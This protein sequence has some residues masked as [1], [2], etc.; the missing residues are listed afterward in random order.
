MTHSARVLMKKRL[1]FTLLAL[2]LAGCTPAAPP[3][4]SPTPD[5]WAVTEDLDGTSWL[6]ME[7]NGQ[8]P[9]PGS[10][11]S[12]EFAEGRVGGYAGCNWYGGPYPAPGDASTPEVT[13]T[14][15]ARAC[16]EPPGV[17]EQESA[18]V[19]ALE[20]AAARQV[21]GSRLTF[22]DAAGIGILE[23]E[24]EQLSQNNP[25][26]LVGTQWQLQSVDG[27]PLLPEA[28][29][30]LR[31]DSAAALSGFAGC[32]DYRGTYAATATDITL[33]F[34]EMTTMECPDE[35]RLVAEGA[36][37][38]YLG[39]IANYRLEGDALTVTTYGGVVL[40]FTTLP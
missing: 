30:T 29:P 12:L 14:I 19:R 27:Q 8:P 22:R 36:Y 2:A 16:A 24:Q 6:L 26:D 7:L 4:P 34:L 18:Y 28:P 21:A 5:P 40:V 25:A 20:S 23:F 38:T 33:S 11:I 39:E 9:I 17:L 37:T 10:R 31:F 35:A 1:L 32:R 15:T 13:F 3:T